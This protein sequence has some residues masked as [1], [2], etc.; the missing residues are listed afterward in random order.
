MKKQ[1]CIFNFILILTVAA[2]FATGFSDGLIK[3]TSVVTS[4]PSSTYVFSYDTTGCAGENSSILEK[5]EAD[6]L[7]FGSLPLKSVDLHVYN[8]QK[9]AV[10]GFPFGVKLYSEGVLIVGTSE[11]VSGGKRYRPAENAGLQ[12]N[13]IIVSLD[14]MPVT[15]VENVTALIESSGGETIRIIFKR[16]GETKETTLC[17]VFSDDAGKYQAGLWIRDNTSGLGTVTFYIPESGLFAGLGHGITDVDSG[18]IIPLMRGIVTSAEISG[19][20]RG[21]AGKPGELQGYFSSGQIGTLVANTECGVFG[22]FSEVPAQD[23]SQLLSFALKDEIKAGEAKLI[24][25]T[26]DSGPHAYNVLISG[27]ARDSYGNKNFV[28]TVTDTD[29]IEKTGGIVQGMSGSPI[30]QNGKIVGAVTHVL[31]N[32]PTRGY[33]ILIENMLKNLPEILRG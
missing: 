32:D 27:I 22:V 3:D 12:K 8:G 24:C 33:G 28:I 29:L 21:K 6:V 30:V 19:V 10:G 7:L 25:T 5:T 4:Q 31:I 18:E 1:T 17:P 16:N 2:L 23:E 13:D 20:R 15:A 14:G 11:I 9:A 26:D